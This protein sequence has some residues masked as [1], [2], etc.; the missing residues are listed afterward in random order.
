MIDSIRFK[1]SNIEMQQ[2]LLDKEQR[3]RDI[4]DIV[5]QT[6]EKVQIIRAVNTWQGPI[7][8]SS[9]DS[10]SGDECIIM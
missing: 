1:L 2:Q 7:D 10:S 5:Q 8:G 4:E 6:R 9:E 3:L